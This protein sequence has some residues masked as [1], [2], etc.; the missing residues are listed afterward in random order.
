MPVQ[1]R[2]RL[3]KSKPN[4]WTSEPLALNHS[5]AT[6]REENPCRRALIPK[7]NRIDPQT[8]PAG[9]LN[10]S[11]VKVSMQEESENHGSFRSAGM[12]SQSNVFYESSKIEWTKQV[13]E[14]L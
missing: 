5:T 6:E 4:E 9:D 11:E 3:L 12:R 14:M 1:N 2:D 10:T 8:M 13:W 7:F